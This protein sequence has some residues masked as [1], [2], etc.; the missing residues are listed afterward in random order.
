MLAY[1]ALLGNQTV[2]QAR[3]LPPQDPKRFSYGFR[4]SIH[5]HLAPP[6]GVFAEWTGNVKDDRH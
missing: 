1:F 6:I 5:I 4:C 2:A 3:I